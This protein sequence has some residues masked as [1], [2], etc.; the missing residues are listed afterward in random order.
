MGDNTKGDMGDKDKVVQPHHV[1]NRN[2][3]IPQVEV[4]PIQ[5]KCTTTSPIANNAFVVVDVV[6]SRYLAGPLPSFISLVVA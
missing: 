2:R 3:R 1:R 6:F 5:R 4:T